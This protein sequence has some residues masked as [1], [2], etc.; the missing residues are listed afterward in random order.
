MHKLT[1]VLEPKG[2]IS[3]AKNVGIKDDT[4]DFTVIFSEVPAAAAGMFT[5]NRFC[6]APVLV[7]RDHLADGVLQAIV[8]NSKNANVATGQSGIDDCQAIVAAVGQELAIDPG[9]ILPSS[10]GVIGRRLPAD[11]M[12]AGIPG[13][14]QMMGSGKLTE[15]AHAIMTTDTRPKYGSVRIGDAVLFGMAKGAGMIE[16]NLATMLAYFFTDAQIS[17]DQ[18]KGMLHRVV[19]KSFNR[20]SVDTDTSTSDTVICM[21]NGLAGEVNL[22]DFEE[23][24]T[25]L[26]IQLARKIAKDGEG[27]TK[28]IEV[29]VEGTNQEEDAVKLAKSIVNSPLLKTA[30]FGRDPNWGRVA[31]AMGKAGVDFTPERARI[32][33]GPHLVFDRGAIFEQQLKEVEDYLQNEE[34]LIRV[35]VGDG[36]HSSTVWGCDLTYEYVRINGE[37]TT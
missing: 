34:I 19:N 32:W 21:A 11:R 33:F 31:M 16:P 1:Q 23:A 18:L 26:A 10:T 5:T 4:L 3:A 13:I 14:R 8:V 12:I 17:G 6:G 15:A 22:H 29:Q 20:V 30:V 25:S 9:L 37:Y 36:I 27:A 2:F 28:L 35:S 24:F 7:G